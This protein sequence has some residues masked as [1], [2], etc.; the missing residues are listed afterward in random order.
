M[1]LSS[2]RSSD[3]SFSIPFFLWLI[4]YLHLQRPMGSPSTHKAYLF[5]VSIAFILAI[6]C[7]YSYI[8]RDPF[9]PSSSP[10]YL[11]SLT[12][13]SSLN[14]FFLLSFKVKA[15]FRSPLKALS[16][17]APEIFSSASQLP[18]RISI[19]L[20]T[21]WQAL[22]RLPFRHLS[23][24]SHLSGFSF[25]SSTIS[26]TRKEL[27]NYGISLR[28]LASVSLPPVAPAAHSRELVNICL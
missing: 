15:M 2:L 14:L 20:F 16:V 17:Q 10:I 23:Q 12:L 1:V 6:T 18:I 11:S 26:G 7:H 3:R 9:S 25:P 21:S 19:P 27:P 28:R 4:V 24:M 5:S 22:P 13:K 8:N